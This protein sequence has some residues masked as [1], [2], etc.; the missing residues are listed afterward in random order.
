MSELMWS[1]DFIILDGA[2]SVEVALRRVA[3][4]SAPWIIVRGLDGLHQY[5]LRANEILDSPTLAPVL[6]NVSDLAQVSL[7]AALELRDYHESTVTRSRETISPINLSWQPDLRYASVL[8]YIERDPAG[9]I[10]AVGAFAKGGVRFGP[11][12][13]E[14]PPPAAGPDD[15]WTVQER[16]RTGDQSRPDGPIAKEQPVAVEGDEGS[17]PVRYPSIETD[18]APAAGQAIS[19]TVDLK[20]K[21]V[22]DTFGMLDLGKQASTWTSLSLRV[23]LASAQVDFESGGSGEITIRRN[24]DSEPAIIKGR[25][26]PE[27]NPGAQIEIRGKFY[28]RTRHCGVAIRTFSASAAEVRPE[29]AEAPPTTGAVVVERDAAVPDLTIDI[30]NLDKDHPGKLRWSAVTYR[31]D[32]L[33]PELSEDIDLGQDTAAEAVAL[34]KGFAKL[35]PGKHR[36]RIEGFGSGLWRR[37]PRMFRDVYWAMWDYYKRPMTIQFISDEPHLPWELMCPERDTGDEFHPPLAL[38]H[39]TARWIKRY[40]GYM[41]NH[42][43]SGKLV[44]IAPKYQS[45]SVALPR[46]EAEAQELVNRFSAKSIPGTH[47]EVT[48]LFE[49]TSETD[50]IAVVHFA[51]HG[52]FSPDMADNSFIKLEGTDVF[53]ASEIDVP[54]VT[55]GRACRTLVFFNACEVGAS[56]SVFGGV[57]GWASAF[58][59]RHFGGFIAPL[60]SIEDNDAKVVSADLIERIYK[61]GESIGAA[62]CAIR[63]AY[64]D[65]SPTYFSYL[66]YG[67]VTAHIGAPAG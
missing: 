42:L 5:A 44:T 7:E 61:K 4:T 39:P 30:A 6:A 27:L 54:R 25:V 34:F 9:E 64:G 23:V 52:K 18:T 20:R 11:T 60:W 2:M 12:R 51:G 67:D 31:F 14:P 38:K 26:R 21:E 8:R 13:G 41:R 50:D 66:Y 35:E 45:I 65:R 58:L 15:S 49:H 22:A 63:M 48:A 56:G 10:V 16:D 62:L 33:P 29:R 36:N 17:S 59:A 46:A 43:P 28:D 57:G 53:A 47:M 37:A 55:L 1:G 32:G 40:D 3:A 24:A 19:L